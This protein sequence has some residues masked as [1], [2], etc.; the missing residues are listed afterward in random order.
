MCIIIDNTL[1]LHF[2][3]YVF[4]FFILV[5][6]YPFLKYWASRKTTIFVTLPSCQKYL[7]YL[8]ISLFTYLFICLFIYL[9]A[10]IN[11]CHPLALFAF[12]QIG[13]LLTGPISPTDIQNF[14][15][16]STLCHFFIF[17]PFT[18]IVYVQGN[19]F[20]LQ[21]K[22]SHVFPLHNLK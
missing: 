5:N 16:K 12:L 20:S 13:N 7:Y 11:H 14:R 10:F 19:E 8:L 18:P 2:T 22:P 3:T 4:T 9:L 17:R 15:S 1:H 6:L 21:E